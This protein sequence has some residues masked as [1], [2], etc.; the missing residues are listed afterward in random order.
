MQIKCPNCGAECEAECE[1]TVGQHVICP[2]RQIVGSRA[3]KRKR[4][5][6]E[7]ETMFLNSNISACHGWLLR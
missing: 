6:S 7:N 4:R 5:K 1:L 3:T 2:Y